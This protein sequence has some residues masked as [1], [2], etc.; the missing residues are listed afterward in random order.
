MRPAV[1]SSYL[2][3]TDEPLSIFAMGISTEVMNKHLR[4]RN[5]LPISSPATA[6]S[7]FPSSEPHLGPSVFHAKPRRRL[8]A[9]ISPEKG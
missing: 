3:L 8:R 7:K 5:H 4:L 2:L 9:I 6:I 1:N